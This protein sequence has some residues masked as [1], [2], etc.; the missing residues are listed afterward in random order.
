M[1]NFSNLKNKI[2]PY[3]AQ[4]YAYQSPISLEKNESIRINQLLDVYGKNNGAIY[5]PSSNIFVVQDTIL[6]QLRSE[7][8]K[9]LEYHFHVPGEHVI[10]N[11]T[12]NSEVHYVF[13][14]CESETYDP[15][16]CPDVCGCCNTTNSDILVIGRLISNTKKCNE[17]DKLNVKIPCKYFEYD[18]TL[19][20]GL[21]SPVRWII[22]LHSIEL[23][24]KD[25]TPVAKT[26]R[27]L[28]SFDGRLKLLCYN[29]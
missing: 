20:T 4:Q 18:G 19:T 5:D 16:Y 13:V 14:N 11:K 27:S 8:Y 25:I 24:I 15:S 6:L 26:A 17:L 3:M 21:Y 2:I 12:Y 29:C 1:Y 28:Q 10:D 22:G 7:K 23:S 9:L